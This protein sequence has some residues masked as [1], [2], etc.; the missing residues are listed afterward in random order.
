MLLDIAKGKR[1]F[2]VH[3]LANQACL[4]A[5]LY[6]CRFWPTNGP[7]NACEGKAEGDCKA[8]SC[9]WCV[10]AAVGSACYTPVRTGGQ[11]TAA[12]HLIAAVVRVLLHSSHRAAVVSV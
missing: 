8:S 9:A 2:Q 6:P 4:R 3:A 11:V 12:L 7:S 1:V 5:D 10:S